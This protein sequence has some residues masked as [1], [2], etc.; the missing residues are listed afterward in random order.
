MQLNKQLIAIIIL[1]ALLLSS[2]VAA[3]F[4]YKKNKQTLQAK[5][6]LVTVYIAKD[7]IPTGTL[8]S[9]DHMA[10]TQIAKEFILNTPLTK[11]EILGKFT[12]EKIY[13]HEIFLKQKLDTEIKKEQKK[14]LPFEKSAYN[15]KFELFKNPNYALQQGEYINIVSVY[16]KGEPDKQGRY[17]DFDVTYVAP[18]IKILGFIRDGRY[19]SQTITKQTVKKVVQKKLQDVVEEVKS[20]ELILD[21]NLD[22]LLQLIKNYNLGT[23]LWMTKTNYTKEEVETINKEE[24][25]PIIESKTEVEKPKVI[26]PK[27]YKYVMYSPSKT[28]IKRSAIITYGNKQ[29]QENS[30]S[31]DV[32]IVVNSAKLCTTIKDRFIVGTALR[33]NIRPSATTSSATKESLVKNTIIPYISK[34]GDWY[35]TCDEKFVHQSVVNEV[36]AA[37]VNSKL[38][39]YE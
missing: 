4:F 21:V 15:M 30:K 9:V 20:D 37:F 22:V 26:V 32:D 14:I 12:N 27:K 35:K 18:S 6:E 24:S 1:V 34:V 3:L 7:D 31:K 17:L 38:G 33:F 39:Q 2:I 25:K 16:P 11:N 8:L 5:S 10:Q 19:E 23:Q 29:T 36:D 13:K 28:V